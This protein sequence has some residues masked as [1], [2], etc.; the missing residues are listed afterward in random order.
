MAEIGFSRKKTAMYI[1]ANK[2]VIE[3]VNNHPINTIGLSSEYVTVKNLTVTGNITGSRIH[4]TFFNSTQINTDSKLS[5]R[6]VLS[7]PSD[8]RT[9]IN[10]ANIYATLDDKT[11][12]S[13][14]YSFGQ[15]NGEFYVGVG[16]STDGGGTLAT[17][18]H[19]YNGYRWYPGNN[20]S[21]VITTTAN[22]VDYD[23]MLY[24]A[25]GEGTNTHAVS[26]D[27][28]NW[29]GLGS[30]LMNTSCNI[31]KHENGIWVCGGEAT[32]GKTIG[33][34]FDGTTWHV[35]YGAGGVAI[36]TIFDSYCN[37]L[38]YNGLMWIATGFDSNNG[39]SMAFSEDGIQ[40]ST[41]PLSN[42]LFSTQGDAVSSNGR[43]F[44]SSGTGTN[45]LA[46]SRDGLNWS[47]ITTSNLT[48]VN[49]IACNGNIWVIG[50][51]SSNPSLEYSI[52]DGDTFIPVKALV[53]VI[54][55]VIYSIYWTGSYFIASGQGGGATM[56][57]S[58]DG[59]NWIPV[60]ASITFLDY[61]RDV[62]SN[63]RKHSTIKFEKKTSIFCGGG[64]N[65]LGIETFSYTSPADR[66]ILTYTGISGS[67]DIFNTRATGVAHNG[68]IWVA[69]GSGTNYSLAYSTN[70]TVWQGIHHSK[71]RLFTNE[72]LAIASNNK[73]WVAT[74]TSSS[75][76]DTSGVT[77]AYSHDGYSWVPI[78]NSNLIISNPDNVIWG[79]NK[80]V[81]SS[82]QNNTIAI[83]I[84]GKIW[85]DV[86][87]DTLTTISDIAWNGKMYV[88]GGEGS[89][90]TLSWSSNAID[91]VGSLKTEFTTICR[92]I[93]WSEK[94]KIWVAVGR[95]TNTVAYSHDGVNWTGGGDIIFTGDATS[96]G[97]GVFYNGDRFLAFGSG[98]QNTLAYSE[99]GI[100]WIATG[101]SL[102]STLSKGGGA[103][104]QHGVV[105]I[106]GKVL[107]VGE[108]NGSSI[109]HSANGIDWGYIGTTIF[110]TTALDVAY[111]GKIWVAVGDG[112][113]DTIGY[114]YDGVNWVGAGKSALTEKGL[115]VEWNGS[116]WLA[117]G[118]GTNKMAISSDGVVWEA[119]IQ[120][121]IVG[122]CKA[123]TW[124]GLKWIALGGVNKIAT[125]T[126]GINWAGTGVNQAFNETCAMSSGGLITVV[127]GVGDTGIGETAGGKI[128]YSYDGI[129]WTP[130]N[131]FGGGV[132]SDI[133]SID[134]HGVANN[135]KM[136]VAMGQGTNTSAYSY[137]GI[138]WYP[139]GSPFSVRGYDA[140][141]NGSYWIGVGV[142]TTNHVMISFD[143]IIWI[144]VP[145]TE[146]PV[147]AISGLR[148]I[149]GESNLTGELVLNKSRDGLSNNMLIHGPRYYADYD[150]EGYSSF[151]ATVKGIIT[152]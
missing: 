4:N 34:S 120:T 17:I 49:A 108:S 88:A 29:K 69:S 133:F 23:G 117:G 112:I 31:I 8:K 104:T 128:L 70:G 102:F 51:S 145:N 45:K 33:Y 146:D 50:G 116:I 20:A 107:V 109:N 3:T 97:E 41:V 90:N 150:I 84:D 18:L 54:P 35:A 137:D 143:G 66:L 77:I 38:A 122:Q 105:S 42:I 152:E 55:A 12:G 74:G 125:S 16:K 130:C 118:R 32:N 24:V 19:S 67:T 92:A 141:W 99:N 5:N 89:T 78:Y 63:N 142:G 134:V 95:G 44:I 136:W 127:G 58:K 106:D 103:I 36:S 132:I 64:A 123:V 39:S 87:N 139:G 101:T 68:K 131:K 93:A 30:P 60:M 40:W 94:F 71:N 53:P 135:G 144:D 98:T 113:N 148:N 126:D 21:N 62:V 25:V 110:Q 52:D 79:D 11:T 46:R 85:T 138:T 129:T 26:L 72:A 149:V 114:S 151:C 14:T 100:N 27:G 6:V 75:G 73:L 115:T 59:I 56:A 2:F 86:S 61:A 76:S 10:E 43:L 124:T 96:G 140:I 1:N 83:S 111:N 37:G 48:V 28:K 119:V 121:A 82:S 65:A 47:A 81:V 91:W 57:R 80:W 7:F 9:V 147:L 22:S 13:Q 15:A